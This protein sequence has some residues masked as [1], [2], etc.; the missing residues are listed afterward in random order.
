[1]RNIMVFMQPGMEA[2]IAASPLIGKPEQ[3]RGP[4]E[5]LG[6]LSMNKKYA[7][8][9]VDADGNKKWLAKAPKAAIPANKK[10]KEKRLDK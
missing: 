2:V 7:L 1:M 4:V 6:R 5:I 3:F 8:W 10:R 9:F